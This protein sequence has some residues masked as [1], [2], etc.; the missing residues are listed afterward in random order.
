MTDSDPGASGTTAPAPVW[1][2]PPVL[3]AAGALVAAGL[4]AAVVLPGR[5]GDVPAAAPQ[6]TVTLVAPLP[7]PTLPP[8]AR[9]AGTALTAVLPATVLAYALTGS[10]PDGEWPLRG[11]LEA[12]QDTLSDGASTATVRV[13]QWRTPE[14]AAAVA[15]ELA[16][17]VAAAGGTVAAPTEVLVGGAPAGTRTD[18]TAA[19]GSGV[20]VWSNGTVVVLLT[21]PAADVAALAD[22]Y[23]L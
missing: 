23:P 9:P 10:A 16:A 11:A 22:A 17:G 15:G 21:G 5:G 2:R 20:A 8:A 14:E 13:G 4:V 19:D 3:V 1:R 12:W 7:T 18:G 6:P